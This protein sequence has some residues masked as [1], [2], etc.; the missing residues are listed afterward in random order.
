ML[1]NTQLTSYQSTVIIIINRRQKSK[2]AFVQTSHFFMPRIKRSANNRAAQN[3]VRKF[4]FRQKIC[5]WGEEVAIM[6]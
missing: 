5:R 2:P 3:E 4:S 6:M 1:L